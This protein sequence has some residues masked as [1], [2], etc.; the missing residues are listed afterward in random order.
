M[1][2]IFHHTAFPYNNGIFDQ[3]VQCCF[4]LLGQYIGIGMEICHLAQGM[5]SGIRPARA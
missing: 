5:D 4:K 2:A 1:E 3:A